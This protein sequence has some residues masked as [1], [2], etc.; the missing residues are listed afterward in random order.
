MPIDHADDPTERT[1]AIRRSSVPILPM[2]D[3]GHYLAITEGD[4]LRRVTIGPDGILVG[5]QAPATL[6]IP[7]PDISR[8]HCRIEVEG[9]WAYATD[10]DSTNGTFLGGR[11]LSRRTR[12]PNGASLTFGSVSVRYERRDRKEVAAEAELTAE[13]RRAAEY[14]RAILPEPIPS[15]AVQAEWC[16]I[17]ST[18]LGGDAFGY[19]FLDDDSFAGFVLDVSGHGIGSAMHAVNVANALRRRTLPDVDFRHPAQV[20]RGLNAAFPMEEHNGLLLTVWYFVYDLPSRV[21][22]YATGGHHPALLFSPGDAAPAPLAGQ[23]PTIGMMPVGRWTVAEATMPADARLFVF[24]DGAFEIE[25]A[26]GEAWDLPDLQRTMVTAES[27]GRCDPQR[28]YDLVRAAARPG[29]LADDFSVLML[30]FP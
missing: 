5:R 21:L 19:Q 14:V 4:T 28:L 10:L 12:L 3:V 26:S 11:R 23:G 9:E 17:P 22:R 2:A 8:R 30:R 16:F 18:Q 25:T 20:V 24:S 1:M 15:G 6:A 27:V 29:P 13:L 7:S